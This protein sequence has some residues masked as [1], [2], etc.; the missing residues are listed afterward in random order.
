MS[1]V[2]T[3]RTTRKGREGEAEAVEYLRS[4][5]YEI[6]ET[7]FRSKAGEIDVIAEKDGTLAFLE[8]KSWSA[9]GESELEYSINERKQRRIARTAQY[10]LMNRPLLRGRKFRFDVILMKGGDS[11]NRVRHIENAFNGAVG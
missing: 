1:A 4:T 9:Y 2:M 11:G 7:N 6:L 3:T 5:G 8:V 10:F